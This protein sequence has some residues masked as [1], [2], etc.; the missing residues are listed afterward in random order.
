MK[1]QLHMLLA[2]RQ[3]ERITLGVRQHWLPWNIFRRIPCLALKYPEKVK[4]R[5][6]ELEVVLSNP[7]LAPTATAFAVPLYS[8]YNRRWKSNWIVNAGHLTRTILFKLARC[9]EFWEW[10]TSGVSQ[11]AV[12]SFSIL[13]FF[14]NDFVLTRAKDF[15]VKGRVEV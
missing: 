8:D 7:S 4:S 15:A 12:S 13:L 2:M 5:F 11:G 1:A 14:F 9:A 6:P 10:S 3:W